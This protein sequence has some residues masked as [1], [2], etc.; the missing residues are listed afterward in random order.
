MCPAAFSSGG[1]RRPTRLCV[2]G[3]VNM[4]QFFTVAV[5]PR[6]GETVLASSA[7]TAPGGKG[8][9]QAIAAARAGAIVQFVGAVGA[10][11]AG[12]RLRGHLLDNGLGLD[13]VEELPVPSGGAVIT[14]DPAGENQIVVAPGA[15]AHLTLASA[16]ARA[17]IADCEVLLVQLEIPIATAVAAAREARSVGATVIVNASPVSQDAAGLAEHRLQQRK[18]GGSEVELLIAGRCSVPLAVDHHSLADGH[19]AVG[20]PVDTSQQRLHSL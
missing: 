13:G 12:A 17:V 8:G 14:V 4:D 10:D 5:L 18:F 19:I 6:P 16:A 7:T 11:A 2:V 20:A 15:N 3:S 9:N 1:D